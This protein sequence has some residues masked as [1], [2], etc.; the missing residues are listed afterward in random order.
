MKI[1]VKQFEEAYNVNGGDADKT[2]LSLGVSRATYFRLKASAFAASVAP[3]QAAVV[4]TA[5]AIIAAVP[6]SAAIKRAPD[7][8]LSAHALAGPLDLSGYIPRLDGDLADYSARAEYFKK[9]MTY[10]SAARSVLLFGEAGVGKT[11]IARYLA[12]KLGLP[13]LSVSCD[14]LLGFGELFGQINITDGTS[15]FLPGLFLHFLQAPSIILIDEVTALD[16]AKSFKLHQLLGDKEVLVKEA[17][18]GQGQLFKVHPKCFIILAGNPPNSGRYNG[19]N[20]ANVALIDRPDAIIEMSDLSEDELSAI[21]PAH[22]E[23]KNIIRYYREAREV[24]SKN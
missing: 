11:S 9:L 23:K 8:S 16:P 13:F 2:I 21:I 20:K 1:S 15:H 6:P 19:T 5:E 24:I 14:V 7:G 4:A 22:A 18:R 10:Y 12:A 17:N 3:A